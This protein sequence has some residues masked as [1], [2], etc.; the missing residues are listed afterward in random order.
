MR[1][2]QGVFIPHRDEALGPLHLSPVKH[3]G[4]KYGKMMGY[5]GGDH[6]NSAT[7]KSERSADRRGVK[8]TLPKLKFMGEA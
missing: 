7:C 6:M 1:T 5:R 3:R 2:I 8:V 4:G